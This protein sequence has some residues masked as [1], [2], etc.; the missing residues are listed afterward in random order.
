MF[1]ISSFL[2]DFFFF[3]DLS[4][5]QED[6]YYSKM[7]NSVFLEQI[8]LFWGDE[9]LFRKITKKTLSADIILGTNQKPEGLC[10]SEC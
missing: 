2:E 3:F 1:R 10:I 4:S 9:S 5:P 8:D 6:S 7:M